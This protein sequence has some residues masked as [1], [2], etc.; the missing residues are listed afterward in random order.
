MMSATFRSFRERETNVGKMSI[1]D[2]WRSLGKGYVYMGV[3]IY[4][5]TASVHCMI[6]CDKTKRYGGGREWRG[7]L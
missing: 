7:T 5:H 3:H 6:R 2:K 1:T 4:I